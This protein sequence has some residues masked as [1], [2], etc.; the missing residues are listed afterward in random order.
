MGKEKNDLTIKI[1]ALIIAIILWSYVMSEVDPKRSDYHNVNVNFLNEAS[2]ERQGLVVLDTENASVR[3]KISG[4]RSELIKIK[5]SDIIA[6]VDLSGYSE[7]RVKVP[8]YVQAPS[9]VTVEDY[10][11]KEIL[12][13][14]DRIITREIP[15]TVETIGEV[16]EGNVL[17]IPEV[18]PQYVA[19]EGP[20]TWLNSVWKVIASVDVSEINNDIN[21]TRGIRIVDDKDND[22]RGITSNVNV[23]D[24]SIPVFKV[25][26][27]PIELII[28]NQLPE[29]YEIADININPSIISIVGKKDILQSINQI[30]TLPVDILTLMN[31]KN[32]PVDLDIPEGI[33]LVDED[34]KVTV[35]LNVEEIV[36][37]T[38]EYTL[39][40]LE[41][42]NLNPELTIAEEDM[43]KTFS[44]TIQGTSSVI[45]ALE[46]EDIEIILD[47]AEL[48]EGPH[49]VPISVREEE[50]TVIEILPE[51][52]E[53]TLISQ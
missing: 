27:V 19:L 15:V 11:P 17:G 24:I 39:E 33:K 42:S 47:L 52:F 37:K 45:E 44:L 32:V 6:Q 13:T 3:V 28:E 49:R 23:V 7:G 29:N 20:R 35:T 9:S 53:I 43:S 21:V 40:D 46:A 38:F 10:S 12:I 50:F 26:S 34:V 22:V 51:A 4:R 18:R 8:V 36:T 14:F 16:P 48:E 1:L 31:E 25:K 5:E 2:L 41:I 30:N